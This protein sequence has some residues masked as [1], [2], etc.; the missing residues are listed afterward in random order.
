MHAHLVEIITVVLLLLSGAR[1]ALH[2][3]S[4]LRDGWRSNSRFVDSDRGL[5]DPLTLFPRDSPNL[6]QCSLRADELG[7]FVVSKV[8]NGQQTWELVTGCL[9]CGKQVRTVD[10]YASRCS[11]RNV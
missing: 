10:E 2:D 11:K 8:V 1:L 3:F 4:L 7:V 6:L 5:S 9:L